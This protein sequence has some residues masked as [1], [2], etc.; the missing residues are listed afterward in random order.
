MKSLSLFYLYSFLASLVVG[1]HIFSFKYI[2]VLMK[3]KERKVKIDT[4]LRFRPRF[5]FLLLRF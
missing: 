2:D 5:L 1:F 3:N 4:F